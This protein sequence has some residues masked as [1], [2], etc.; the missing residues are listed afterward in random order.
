VGQS[1][2]KILT[3]GTIPWI[4][5]TVWVPTSAKGPDGR[6]YLYF[7]SHNGVKSKD[8]PNG[9]TAVAVADKP[10]GPYVDA[11]DGTRL[12]DHAVNGG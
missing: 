11:L 6:Y 7:S 8:Q 5:D 10:Q 9:G 4:K 12:L 1:I 2:P 3:A